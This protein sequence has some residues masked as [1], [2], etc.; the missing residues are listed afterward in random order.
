MFGGSRALIL[1]LSVFAC[2]VAGAQA[3]TVVPEDWALKPSGLGPDGKFRLI[4][5]SSTTRKAHSKDIDD[6]NDFVQE[7]AAT[8]HSAIQTY[9]SGFRVVGCTSSV[10][11]RNNTETTYTA[12]DKGV[13]IYWL[14]GAK[15]ANNYSQFYSESW[16]NEVDSK[17]EFGNAR[18]LSS[19]SENY[20]F[21]G[22]QHSGIQDNALG[23]PAG[24]NPGAAEQ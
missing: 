14:N 15:V 5:A 16:L 22:C 2:L 8:G 12:D 23:R 9:S 4:F 10:S 3:Q 18:N 20:P 13:P 19:N 1:G 21:T 11:A 24:V 17:D 6:Y 7:R